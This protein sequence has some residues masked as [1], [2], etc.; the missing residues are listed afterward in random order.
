[1]VDEALFWRKY[2][3]PDGSAGKI[4]TLLFQAMLFATSSVFL[5]GSASPTLDFADSHS[6]FLS[7]QPKNV[8]TI[9]FNPRETTSTDEPRYPSSHTPV[10]NTELTLQ[11]LYELGVEKDRF[12]VAQASLLLTYYSTDAER[13]NNSRWLRTAIRH[14]KKERAHLYH[15]LQPCKKT[16]DLK[17]LWWCC[18]IRDRIISLGMRRPIQITPDEFDL[19]QPGLSFEDLQE[20]CLQS[21]VYN[22]ETK[23]ALCRVLASLCHLVVAVT[24]SILLVYPTT[25]SLPYSLAE[26]R[27]QLDRLEETKFAL[28]EW[29]FSWV[30]NPDGK[31]YYIH[32]SLTLYTNLCAIYYQ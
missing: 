16:L 23:V 9:L 29:E 7:K 2:R 18:M 11:R 5:L 10:I 25:H 4:S 3:C 32:P 20:E 30:A 15:H 19:N 31:E 26:R 14:A 6:L 24:E 8:D 12:V 13:S 17:R 1:V 21:E 28:L 22:P 27:A